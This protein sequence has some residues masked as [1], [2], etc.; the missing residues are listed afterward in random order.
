[1]RGRVTRVAHIGITVR[2]LDRA[3]AFYTDVVGMRLTER[4]EY[5][6]Q[7]VGHGGAVK[8]GAFVRADHT[9]HA[10]SIFQPRDGLLPDDA[11]DGRAFGIGLHHIAF[12]VDSVEDLLA[13]YRRVRDSGAE[14]VQARYGGPGNHARFYAR[15]PDG[16][17]VEF[18][19]SI[20]TIGWDGIPREYEP[21]TEIDDFETFDFDAYYASR[22]QHARQIQAAIDGVDGIPIGEA[23]LR[24][25]T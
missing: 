10:V 3:V 24:H 7:E 15:D 18:F 5:P 2:N 9:H 23:R 11:P 16:N 17:L 19:W 22:E 1:M 8:A 25:P 14:I 12:G 20:D 4:F 6:E 21:I 13:L